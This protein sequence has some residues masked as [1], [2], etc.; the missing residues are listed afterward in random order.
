ME[1][2]LSFAFAEGT[3]RLEG[4]AFRAAVRWAIYFGLDPSGPSHQGEG[5]GKEVPRKNTQVFFP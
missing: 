1:R 4:Q 3:P 2:R 5:T